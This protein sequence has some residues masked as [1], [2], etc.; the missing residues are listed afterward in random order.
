M[1]PRFEHKGVGRGAPA[2]EGVHGYL[3]G[4]RSFQNSGAIGRVYQTV[5]AGVVRI[6]L[7]FQTVGAD[8]MLIQGL[9]RPSKLIPNDLQLIETHEQKEAQE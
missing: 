4:R 5:T 6:R 7:A 9:T 1:P 8:A 2:A 3:D